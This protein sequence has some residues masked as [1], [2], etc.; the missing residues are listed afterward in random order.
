MSR[1]GQDQGI[2][3]FLAECHEAS[4][5]WDGDIEDL[6]SRARSGDA[7]AR[8]QLFEGNMEL[9]ALLALRLRPSGVREQDAMQEGMLV[10]KK[11][12][13]AGDRSLFLK[14]GS[15]IDSVLTAIF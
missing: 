4:L 7:S 9:A 14:L 12:V 1:R 10:L 8:Q 6:L 5:H 2:V 15:A 11:L 3:D 13:D